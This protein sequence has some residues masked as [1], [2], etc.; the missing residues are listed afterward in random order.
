MSF[1]FFKSL[2]AYLRIDIEVFFYSPRMFYFFLTVFL[3]FT[4]FFDSRYNFSY[5]LSPVWG[6]DCMTHTWP[7]GGHMYM[8]K[9]IVIVLICYLLMACSGGPSVAEGFTRV[10]VMA[11][12]IPAGE[13]ATF[14]IGPTD[15][16]LAAPSGMRKDAGYYTD[17]EQP[18]HEVSLSVPYAIGKYEYGERRDMVWCGGGMLMPDD[19]GYL[20]IAK[21]WSSS[22]GSFY[23]ETGFRIASALP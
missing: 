19:F 16:E 20:R 13:T 15:E 7:I 5:E 3:L 23:M 1:F 18:A 22:P 4:T 14:L 6:S 17:D 21:R 8:Q 11:T 9:T 2:C 12:I 10:P